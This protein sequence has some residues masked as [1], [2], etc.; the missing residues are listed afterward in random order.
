VKV[1][2]VNV[3]LP[4]VVDWR[5]RRVETAIF[6]QP[7]AGTVRVEAD[8]LEGDQQAD[9]RLHGGADK[10]VY[11]YPAEHYPYWKEVYPDLSL[12][13]GAFGENLTT[14]GLAESELNIGDRLRVGTC[15]LVVTHPRLPCYKLELRLGQ[16]DAIKRFL[17][18]ERSGIYFKVARPGEVGAD[19]KIELL[20]RDP[21]KLT[22]RDAA[23]LYTEKTPDL[24][25]LN[26]ASNHPQLPASWR[27]RFSKKLG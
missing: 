1:V 18:S 11:A 23:R 4:R 14:E 24:E 13:W 15:E 21:R 22:V 16:P 5:G 20:E 17:A 26:V 3:G 2:C 7:V 12:G 10:A 8:N 25:M 27:E 19:D 6:K 9:A